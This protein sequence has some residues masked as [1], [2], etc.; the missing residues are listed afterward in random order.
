MKP[1]SI[2][3]F[4]R[5]ARIKSGLTQV[6]L[7]AALG[8]SSPQFVSNWERGFCKPPAAQLKQLTK[9]LRLNP[10][11]LRALLIADF[12]TQLDASLKP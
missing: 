9:I 12:T 2:H 11:T 8:Y 7:A 6:E 1:Q 4:L 10:A 5:K 3:Q